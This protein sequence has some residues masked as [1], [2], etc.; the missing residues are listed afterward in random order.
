MSTDSKRSL[1]WR[2]SAASFVPCSLVVTSMRD[3][4]AT[5]PRSLENWLYALTDDALRVT[6]VSAVARRQDEVEGRVPRAPAG[7]ANTARSLFWRAVSL[8]CTTQRRPLQHRHVPLIVTLRSMYFLIHLSGSLHPPM[9][10]VNP[11]G[12]TMTCQT[13]HHVETALGLQGPPPAGMQHSFFSLNPHPVA[14]RIEHPCLDR[15][16]RINIRF[17]DGV[18]QPINDARCDEVRLGF[19]G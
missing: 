9:S 5:Q 2:G 19:G 4:S 8:I 6:A 1:L 18:C 14:S 13:S 3:M 12:A 16:R 10:S 11:G 17:Q 7:R 15:S